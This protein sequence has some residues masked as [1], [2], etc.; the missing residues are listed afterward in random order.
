[1]KGT[2]NMRRNLILC[3]AAGVVAAAGFFATTPAQASFKVI[4]WEGNNLCQI[5]DYGLPTRPFPADYHVMTKSLP[6]FDV[7]L[8]AKERLRKHGHCSF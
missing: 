3:A 1:M 4:K 6:S 7:A 5:W 2:N 8:S